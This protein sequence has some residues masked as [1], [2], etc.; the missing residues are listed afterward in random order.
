MNDKAAI[1]EVLEGPARLRLHVSG[2]LDRVKAEQL[3][4]RVSAAL[5]VDVRILI[6]DIAAVERIDQDGMR[7]LVDLDGFVRAAGVGYEV[8][9]APPLL[10][11]LLGLA[12]ERF[13]PVSDAHDRPHIDP[14]HAAAAG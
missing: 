2:A 9:N 11:H 13:A 4:D 5:L 1:L 14:H 10:E 3:L 12:W 7:I 6:V 8:V